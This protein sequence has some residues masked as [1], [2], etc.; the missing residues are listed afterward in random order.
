MAGLETLVPQFAVLG[1]KA[2]FSGNDGTHGPELFSTD[3]TAA[4]TAPFLACPADLSVQTADASGA[5]V[6][7]SVASTDRVSTPTVLASPASGTHFALGK[8]TV[9]VISAD[10]AGNSAQCSFQVTVS[11]IEPLTTPPADSS[12]GCSASGTAMGFP[13]ALLLLAGLF[14]RR[15]PAQD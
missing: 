4:G 8:T 6:T 2:Y 12:G 3:G 9:Q 7:F 10:A 11:Q 15:S 1:G 13:L 14:R 5:T